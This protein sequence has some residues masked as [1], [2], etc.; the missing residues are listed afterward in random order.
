MRAIQGRIALFLAAL[1]RIAMIRQLLNIMHHAIQLPLPIYLGLS[2]Q[3]KAVQTLIAAQV[4]PQG[5]SDFLR[6]KARERSYAKHR[7]HR[8]K[9]ARDHFLAQG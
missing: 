2:A 4:A 6:A 7:L 9:A 3:R 1:S 8:R 5:D